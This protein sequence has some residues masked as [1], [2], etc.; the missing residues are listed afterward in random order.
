MKYECSCNTK[1][2]AYKDR[3]VRATAIKEMGESGVD[4][5]KDKNNSNNIAKNRKNS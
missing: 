3:E 5:S 1:C 4:M 2:S